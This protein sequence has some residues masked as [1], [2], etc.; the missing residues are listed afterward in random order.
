MPNPRHYRSFENAD[1]GRRTDATSEGALLSDV[2]KQAL[3]CQS[4]GRSFHKS[5]ELDL[6]ARQSKSRL[7]RAPRPD[8][9]TSSQ[10]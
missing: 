1:N 9:I 5:D 3:W 2:G 7:R 6:R 10:N 4:F 8:E